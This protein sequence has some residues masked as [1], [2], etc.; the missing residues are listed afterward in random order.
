[1]D[2]D[3]ARGKTSGGR[4]RLRNSVH[5]LLV[6]AVAAAIETSLGG[7]VQGVGSGVT[8]AAYALSIPSSVIW[9]VAVGAIGYGIGTI[10][11]GLWGEVAP[12]SRWAPL[13]AGFAVF[14]LAGYRL[15][16]W[17]ALPKGI[18][19]PAGGA[20][21]NLLSDAFV[22]AA[23]IFV[24]RR[25]LNLSFAHSVMM[26]FLAALWLLAANGPINLV[27]RSVPS[28]VG[29]APSPYTLTTETV[30]A[31]ALILGACAVA[32][33]LFGSALP[34]RVDTADTQASRP[35][36]PPHALWLSGGVVL[37]LC[38]VCAA[39]NF[40][41]AMAAS[42]RI[43]HHIAP[44]VFASIPVSIT[45][46]VAI[47]VPCL[48]L[49]T[50]GAYVLERWGHIQNWPGS[51]SCALAMAWFVCFA[52]VWFSAVPASFYAGTPHVFRAAIGLTLD[53]L[54]LY[55]L[56]RGTMQLRAD[57]AVAASGLLIFWRATIGAAISPQLWPALLTT[58]QDVPQWLAR[59]ALLLTMAAFGC[60]IQWC[61]S[62]VARRIAERTGL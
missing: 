19:T 46:F 21:A 41:A 39:V 34:Y 6:A 29:F 53:A 24:A 12:Q 55:V 37:V 47:V 9:L 5:V 62:R 44:E 52:S 10:S 33:H 2:S 14:I 42:N 1:M 38:A 58:V 11:A 22:I 35:P 7:H 17:I 59:S 51:L 54:A 18:I 48:A 61:H 56:L 26:G 49:Q 27:N 20:L 32:Q 45:L 43:G 31:T 23:A 60:A 50:A 36:D 16:M 15:A 57:V 28:F 13:A 40:P 8:A 3:A 30:L 4:G 25:A